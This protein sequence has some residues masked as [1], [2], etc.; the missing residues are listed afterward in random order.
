MQLTK[1]GTIAQALAG[2]TCALLGL[3]TQAGEPGSWDFDTAVLY[4]GEDNGR[5]QALE[6]VVAATRYFADEQQLGIKLTLDSLTGA[7][8]NGATP[9]D[10]PQTFTRPSGKGSYTIAPGEAPL[11][12][13]FK[14]TRGALNLNWSS[15]IN[16]DWRYSTGFNFSAEH[17]YFSA[18]LNGSITRYLN[19]KNTELTLGLAAASDS[20]KP[21]GGVP[22]GLGRV[23]NPGKAN[24]W[25]S[26]EATR[27]GDSDSK[28]LTDVLLGV[29]QV[30]NKRTIMQFNY[31]LSSSSG[32]LTD[33]YKLLS[34]I[35]ANTGKTAVD[36]SGAPIYA[37]EQRPDSRTKHAFFWQTKYML[38]RGDVIDGS[39]R[40]MTDDW[41]VT[42][43]TIDLK[44]HWQLD[45]AYLEPHLRYYLQ[46]EADFYHRYALST[47]YDSATQTLKL[48]DASADY[49]LGE[50][51][52]TTIGLKYA[53]QF[54]QQEFSVRAEYFLQSNSGDKGIGAL[55]NQELYPDTK[56]VMFTLGYSF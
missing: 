12:D 17:D 49:R 40:F 13:T 7:S 28:T 16:S 19:D 14:D 27:Q 42:S 38:E 52:G 33:P 10:Q 45:H 35:D 9:S 29:T 20:V 39:Y 31:S 24:F 51:T 32:Y 21:E 37:Y 55:A 26:F 5:V 48:S 44:Y 43:H 8:P 36:G 56:A 6:P 3:N 22:K 11:D 46:S 50:L 1:S 4:Y 18:G 15:P 41:G 47:D 30:I 23:A 2:A 25:P 53:R 54:N 34:V